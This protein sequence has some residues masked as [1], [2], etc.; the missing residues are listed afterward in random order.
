MSLLKHHA[1]TGMKA[2]D[3]EY[4]LFV[5]YNC[6]HIINVTKFQNKGMLGFYGI[7]FV[8]GIIKPR[9]ILPLHAYYAAMSQECDVKL[10]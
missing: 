2:Y 4:R 7:R 3:D 6:G 5:T 10:T 8:C 1:K 9:I